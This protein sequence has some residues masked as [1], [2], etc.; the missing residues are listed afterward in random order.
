MEEHSVEPVLT[1]TSEKKKRKRWLLLL[2]L[3]LSFG[4]I[5]CIV[6]QSLNKQQSLYKDRD[7]E[8]GIM[9]GMSEEEIQQR[10]NTVVSQGMMNVS[11]NPRPTFKDGASEGSLR[12]ENIKQNHYSY[13]VTITRDDTGEEIYQSGILEPGYFIESAKLNQVLPKG[14]YP[15][16]ARFLAYQ[17]PEEKAIGAAVL[18]IEIVIEK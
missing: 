16:T 9:P 7:A 4:A 2:L 13:Q 17:N 5:F 15:A 6:Y 1:E 10:L 11:M 18:K 3:L 12:I 8:L 14:E